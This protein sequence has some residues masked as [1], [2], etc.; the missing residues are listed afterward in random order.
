MT[1]VAS[2]EGFRGRGEQ[3]SPTHHQDAGL[4]EAIQRTHVQGCTDNRQRRVGMLV[5]AR[6]PE[7]KE[8]E[9]LLTSNGSE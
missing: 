3:A 7:D 8:H 5:L 4:G 6:A 1:A 2:G 9:E